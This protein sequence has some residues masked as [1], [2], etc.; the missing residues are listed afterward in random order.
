[1]NY[2]IVHLF[3]HIQGSRYHMMMNQGLIQEPRVERLTTLQSAISLGQTVHIAHDRETVMDRLKGADLIFMPSKSKF[4]DPQ[5]NGILEAGRLWKRVVMYD[6]DDWPMVDAPDVRQVLLYVKRTPG[7]HG[8]T[9]EGTLQLSY[10]ML[11]EYTLADASQE[12][13]IDVLCLFHTDL[14]KG[15]NPNEDSRRNMLRQILAWHESGGDDL[16][17]Q[18]GMQTT[19]AGRRVIFD[20]PEDNPFLEYLNLLA[21]SKIVVTPVPDHGGGDNRLWEAFGSGALVMSNLVKRESH[22]GFKP[23]QHYFDID[24]LNPHELKRV[25]EIIKHLL[26]TEEDWA[27]VVSAGQQFATINHRAVNRVAKIL[28]TVERI[29]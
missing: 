2:D 19:R 1:M 18:V 22:L 7:T 29:T 26:I 4:H 25:P 9:P 13:D 28:D 16:N 8:L 27:A 24:P 5:V 6:F 15:N 12:R 11:D 21:R 3:N 17:I 23:G 14:L 10:A 20:P